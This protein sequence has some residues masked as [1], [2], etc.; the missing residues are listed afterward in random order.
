MENVSHRRSQQ[1]RHSSCIFSDLIKAGEDEGK[2]PSFPWIH[3]TLDSTDSLERYR[4]LDGGV[5]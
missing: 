4:V 5:E 1:W 2:P 3:V